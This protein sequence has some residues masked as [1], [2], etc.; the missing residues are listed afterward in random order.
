MARK[1]DIRHPSDA[2]MAYPSSEYIRDG[3]DESSGS[4]NPAFTFE[5]TGVTHLVQAWFAQGHSVS[6]FF[7]LTFFI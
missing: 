7:K 2:V 6:L 4:D 5:R 3:V 1:Q